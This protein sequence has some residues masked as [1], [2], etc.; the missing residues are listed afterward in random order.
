M[1]LSTENLKLL[2]GRDES[3]LWELAAAL[4]QLQ[5]VIFRLEANE[6]D[7]A[8]LGILAKRALSAGR[9]L[10]AVLA[11]LDELLPDEE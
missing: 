3:E 8:V 7:P 2:K 9:E 11:I 5:H 6:T 4:L 1:E 10:D